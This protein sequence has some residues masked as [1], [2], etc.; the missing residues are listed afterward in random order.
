MN[1]CFYT[2]E[3][4]SAVDELNMNY[5]VRNRPGH[6]YSFL[7]V[8]SNHSK[9]GFVERLKK[10]YGEIRFNDGRFD[11]H[12]DL[13]AI[14]AKVRAQTTSLNTSAFK[15]TYA[16]AVNDEK[17]I[18]FLRETKPDLIV[19]AGAGILKADTFGL[20]SKAAINVHHGISPEIRGIEST[21][22][23]ML[24]GIRD[25][26]GVTC[27][28]IDETLDTG[29]I[30]TQQPLNSSASSFIDIQSEN[31]LMGRDI[32]LSSVDLL[33]KGGYHVKSLGPVNSYYF[34]IADPFL[35]YAMKK[36]NFQP[37]MKIATKTYKTKEKKILEY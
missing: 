10:I 34:G 9:P 3:Q 2:T 17:S 27:H 18:R 1:I 35:Y 36:R 8:K 25:K 5:L 20:A 32:L 11:L 21:L 31:F 30:I 19:Q 33:D 28:F 13:M 37:I 12:R 15:N 6:N 7:R 26:I 23:C 29:A 4:P 24:Y 16:D 22:W 14:N